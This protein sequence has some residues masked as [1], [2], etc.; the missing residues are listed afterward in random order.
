MGHQCLSAIE[1]FRTSVGMRQTIPLPISHQCLSAIEVFRTPTVPPRP[2]RVSTGHQCLSAI[3]VFR[4]ACTNMIFNNEI[5]V[6]NACRQLR[7]SGHPSKTQVKK[8]MKSHQCLSAI[9]VFRT[10][11]E[12]ELF[13]TAAS[14]TN[15]CRQLRSSGRAQRLST[16]GPACRKVTNACRQLRSSGQHGSFLP[17]RKGLSKGHQCL[18]AIEV[19]RTSVVWDLSFRPEGKSPMP[20]GN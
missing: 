1:V 15:A 18:S 16:S 8:K 3:E 10:L 6:T 13:E 19:F 20:V 9:E 12:A 14:V 2:A 4:T 7:S 5:V 17:T 11:E